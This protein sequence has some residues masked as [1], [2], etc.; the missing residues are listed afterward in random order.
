M[1]RDAILSL[2]CCVLLALGVPALAETWNGGGGDDNWTTGGNWVG[3]VAPASSN[4]TDTILAGTT[5]LTPVVD[6]NNPWVLHSLT[7]NSG[8]GAFSPYGS[9]VLPRGPGASRPGS[10]PSPRR[11]TK[12]CARPT[13]R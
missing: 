10:S 13:R 1:S 8:S 5:R 7:F 9:S 6:T 12:R 2:I 4:T 3:G 11:A